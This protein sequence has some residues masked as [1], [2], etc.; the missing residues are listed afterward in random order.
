MGLQSLGFIGVE[1]FYV[2]LGKPKPCRLEGLGGLRVQGLGL[3]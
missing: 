3:G 2:N 1:D